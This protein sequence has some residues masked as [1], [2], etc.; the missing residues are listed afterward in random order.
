MLTGHLYLDC[1]IGED[2]EEADGEIRFSRM[3]PEIKLADP[4]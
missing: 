3:K 2:G 1:D 4:F